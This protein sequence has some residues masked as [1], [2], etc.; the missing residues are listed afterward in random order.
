MARKLKFC[1]FE[2][3]FY[4]KEGVGG[5]P[6]GGGA[7]RAGAAGPGGGG[8]AEARGEKWAGQS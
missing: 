8:C 7:V 1:F 6:E 3:G 4:K 5:R 2:L